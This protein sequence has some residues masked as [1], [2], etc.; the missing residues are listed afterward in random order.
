MK[1]TIPSGGHRFNIVK[2]RI[3]NDLYNIITHKAF[4]EEALNW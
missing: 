2:S 1:N 3:G 4:N